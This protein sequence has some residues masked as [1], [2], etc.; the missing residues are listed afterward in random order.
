MP[1]HSETPGT[2]GPESGAGPRGTTVKSFYGTHENKIDKKGR[3]SIPAGFRQVLTAQEASTI[4]FFPALRSPAIEV[5]SEE[6]MEQLTR[7]M[8]SFD[9]NSPELED[10]SMTFFAD[11]Y[12]LPVDPEGRVILPE[13][14]RQHAGL[15][16]KAAFVGKGKTFQIWEPGV[17]ARMKAESRA[18]TLQQNLTVPQ[19]D[20]RRPTD[21]GR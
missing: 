21:G 20:P 4:M 16:E 19:I 8:D 17:L 11:A 13:A 18:R 12:P 14:L 9:F 5:C 1:G 15:E 3:V 6:Y 7:N 2:E 10:L